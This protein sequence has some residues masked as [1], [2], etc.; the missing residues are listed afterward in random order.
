VI[1]EVIQRV[2]TPNV[3][4]RQ[5]AELSLKMVRAFAA[6]GYLAPDSP[7]KLEAWVIRKRLKTMRNNLFPVG[8]A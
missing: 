6:A 2:E 5:L 7:N 1:R 8:S 3:T 4:Q